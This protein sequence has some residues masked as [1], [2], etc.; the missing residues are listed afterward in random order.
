M[1][2]DTSFL[3]AFFIPEDELH[4]ESLQIIT[5]IKESANLIIPNRVIEELFTV[6]VYKKSVQYALEI[7]RKLENN[8]NIFIYEIDEEERKVIIRMVQRY[9]IKMSF[10][11]YVVAYLT[12]KNNEELLCF[13]KQVNGFVRNKLKR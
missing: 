6:L 10:T 4:A 8:R 11:D 3:V 1:I 5:E 2:V 9:R 13:D 12:L 7:I